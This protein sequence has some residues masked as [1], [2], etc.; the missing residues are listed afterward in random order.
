MSNTAAT[1]ATIK[2]DENA[3]DVW[4][5]LVGQPARTFEWDGTFHCQYCS[6]DDHDVL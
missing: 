3:T 4:C 2:L 6:S 1:Y 5:D